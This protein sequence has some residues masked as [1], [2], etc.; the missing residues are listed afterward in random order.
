MNKAYGLSHISANIKL[1]TIFNAKLSISYHICIFAGKLISP[2]KNY[3][4]DTVLNPKMF[5]ES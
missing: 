1:V 5:S 3:Y 4:L 2:I